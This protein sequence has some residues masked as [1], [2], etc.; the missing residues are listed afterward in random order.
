MTEIEKLQYAKTY[1][2]K[3][4]EGVNPLTGE[5]ITE[6]TLLNN[7]RISR[8]FY[9]VSGVLDDVIN[10]GISNTSR[11]VKKL[12]FQLTDEQRLGIGISLEPIYISHFVEEINGL[13]NQ[14]I[15]KKLPATRVTKWLVVQGYLM[16]QE[17]Q[18]G[19]KMKVPTEE[20][21]LLGIAQTE[22]RRFNGEFY[23]INVY[24]EHAQKFIIDSL[25]DIASFK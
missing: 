1:I 13:I 5:V 24:D 10:T 20:G 15:M 23:T 2:Q 6:D 16:E 19:G 4:A 17:K 21:K 12:D 22:K 7:V 18:S 3:L 14:D 9:Y 8:C 25:D 11:K